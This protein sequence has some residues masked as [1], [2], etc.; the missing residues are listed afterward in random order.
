[1]G[2]RHEARWSV[3]WSISRNANGKPASVVLAQTELNRIHGG[4]DGI[5]V[6]AIADEPLERIENEF[7]DFLCMT[8]ARAFQTR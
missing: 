5:W 3:R 8:F 4:G 6:D 7:L 2:L 1:M